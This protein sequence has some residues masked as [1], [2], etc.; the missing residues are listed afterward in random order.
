MGQKNQPNYDVSECDITQYR[1][2]IFKILEDIG[3]R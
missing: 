2:N 1:N 3:H